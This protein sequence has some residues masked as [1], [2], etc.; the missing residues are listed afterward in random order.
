M[1]SVA[2]MGDVPDIKTPLTS[3]FYCRDGQVLA[4][5][6][7]QDRF[8]VALG[9]L[10]PY[11]PQAFVAVEDH[12]FYS[13]YGIDPQGLLRAAARNLKLRRFAEGGSTIT[14]QLAKNLFLTHDKTFSRKIQE[15]LL[16]LQLERKFT[17]EEIL[18]KYLNT[19]YFGHSAYGVEAAARVFYDKPA[20]D[21]SLAESA[22]LAGIPRGPAY[23]SPQINF[24]AAKNRQAL[25][26]RRMAEQ[27]MITARQKEEALAEQLV[28]Q[29][30]GA[31]RARQQAGSYFVDHLVR[32]LAAIFPD[33]PQLVFRGGLNIYTTL[34][35]QAQQAAE[36]AVAELEVGF[37]DK[38]GIRQPQAALVALDPRDG[39]VRALVGG[40]D[41][42]ETQLNRALLRSGR[43]PGS[44][45]KPFVYAAA[46]EAGYTPANVHTSEPVTYQI[47]GQPEPYEPVEYGDKF[48]NT[49]M[50]M[51]EALARS[52]N[53]VA[54]KTHMENAGP[55]KTLE[56]A[57][58]LGINSV[59]Q[60]YPSLAVGS[61]NV[62]PLEMALAY[63]PFANQGLK[64]EPLFITGITDARGRVLYENRPA[65][66]PVL[67][68]GIAYQITDM[69]K[70][71]LRPGGTGATLG[72]VVGRPAAAKTGTS[73]G[74]RDSYIVGYTPELVAAVWVGNDNDSSLGFG[75]T[76]ARLAGPLWARFMRDALAGVDPTDFERPPGLV[77]R[78]ICPETG[79][80]HNPRC[81]QTP[82]NELFI[83]G[84]EPVEQCRWPVC[85][86]CPPDWQWH[87]NDWYNNR[88]RRR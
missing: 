79:L 4:T 64:V 24:E 49:P 13:H 16:T 76:G 58:R 59:M 12:R 82:R 66:S 26:L 37:T 3:T 60:P 20:S 56:M 2:G 51:R 74:H 23:Y 50:T 72:P 19:I 77:N 84:T 87:W 53:V 34:D 55:Q 1:F 86:H 18:E 33:D 5:R 29:E 69:L 7:E 43:S 38:E 81:S 57:R 22:M 75:E 46:L 44:A 11:L 17:K 61:F 85:P 10:P 48:Y 31:L 80:L 65:V 40:R 9:D 88:G 45:F 15:A 27:G 35:R 30:R 36:Q 32:E 52:S 62:T 41:F 67:D 71:V 42:R 47:P 6:F 28:I 70:S 63:A 25:V 14:Q 83:A 21:L 73:Q 39:S 78:D 68:P 54:V 8:E